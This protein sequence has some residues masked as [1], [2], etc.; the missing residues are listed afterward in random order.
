MHPSGL[1]QASVAAL[2]EAA[3]GPF[4]EVCS[5]PPSREGELPVPSQAQHALALDWQ[6]RRRPGQ[7]EEQLLSA[8]PR[9]F[10]RCDVG[11]AL[12]RVGLLTQWPDPHSPFPNSPP[13]FSD[14]PLHEVTVSAAETSTI[15]EEALELRRKRQA[16]LLRR[17]EPDL[18]LV[19]PIPCLT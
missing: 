9:V 1:W 17:S 2:R 10:W 3:P 6:Q 8:P 11:A 5:A 19:Q 13:F 12:G 15:L 16:L 7:G 14:T 4:P 18:K